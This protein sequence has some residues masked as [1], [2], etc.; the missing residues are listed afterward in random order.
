MITESDNDATSQL[1]EQ[2]GRGQAVSS[3][4]ASVGVSGFTPDPGTS[5]GASF[6]SAR[7]MAAIL[8]KLLNGEILDAPS[9]ALAMRMLD[10]VVPEQRWGVSAGTDPTS[11]DRVDVKDG[12]Y[13]GEEG[14]R[15]NSVGIVRPR[16]GDPYAIAIVTGGR[17]SWQEGI[18]TIEGIAAPLNAVMRSVQ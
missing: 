9:R 1:W 13:P 10:A 5:W 7:S 12:W 16:T 8:G 14:W 18:D 4:L 2:I 11:G 3:Y 15:V 6:A 17:V